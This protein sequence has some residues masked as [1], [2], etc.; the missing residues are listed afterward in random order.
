MNLINFPKD[1]FLRRKR[2]VDIKTFESVNKLK[3]L[4]FKENTFLESSQISDEYDCSGFADFYKLYLN[5][6]KFYTQVGISRRM[7]KRWHFHIL[8]CP[9]IPDDIKK[10]CIDVLHSKVQKIAQ[11]VLYIADSSAEEFFK[12]YKVREEDPI[13]DFN[14]FFYIQS[15][16][17]EPLDYRKRP[18]KGLGIPSQQDFVVDTYA[19]PD[20]NKFDIEYF[21]T[22]FRY[23][24]LLPRD[25]PNFLKEEI[26]NKR[27]LLFSKPQKPIRP[28]EY[29]FQKILDSFPSLGE[30]LLERIPFLSLV[31]TK[32]NVPNEVAP[33]GSGVP[34]NN[35]PNEVVPTENEVVPTESGVPDKDVLNAVAS[36]ELNVPKK[37]IGVKK[38][39]S[40]ASLKSENPAFRYLARWTLLETMDLK[41]TPDSSTKLSTYLNNE[42]NEYV[43]QLEK[44]E[45]TGRLHYQI[46][47]CLKQKKRLNQ[48]IRE[49]QEH[50]ESIHIEVC[51]G[52]SKESKN[53][54][55]KEETRI[56]GPWSK[57][58]RFD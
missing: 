20:P 45:Q 24:F 58:R 54:C 48:V 31:S 10:V 44:E 25:L 2:K 15:L 57:K 6:R 21:V 7:F 8:K 5:P 9:D 35:M 32:S 4:Y 1:H 56:L 28:R 19:F 39:S 34:D 52:S 13:P 46:F 38:K 36:T 17:A 51:K 11:S 50:F 42:C 55:L 33:I 22:D 23:R 41:E 12:F 29:T 26:E 30:E 16:A 53:Y 47:F 43:F 49:M 3:L 14:V 37:R 27:R 18:I 40:S